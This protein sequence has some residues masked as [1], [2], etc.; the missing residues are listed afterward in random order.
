MMR[1]LSIKLLMLFSFTFMM[2]PSKAQLCNGSLGDP[3]VNITFGSGP[4]PGQPLKAATTS[5]SFLA[6]DC[7]NDGY[8]TIENRTTNCYNNTWYS[9]TA[10]HTGDPN[11]YFMLVNASY[12]PGAFYLDTVKGLCGGITYE[13]AA[14]ILNLVK[15]DASIRPNITFSIETTSGTVLQSY[16][17]G[18]ILAS[19]SPQWKQYGFY[20]TTPVNAP[21]I[22]LRMVNNAQGGIGNDVALDDITFR[23][24]GPKL[25]VQMNGGTTSKEVCQ[26]DKTSFAFSSSIT[27]SY[28]NPSYQW[29]VSKDKGV[30]WTDIAGATGTSY[31]RLP[32]DTGAYLYRLAVAE[33]DNISSLKCRVASNVLS[34]NVQPN[35]D[36]KIS[37]NNPGCT[38]DTLRL[39]AAS[40]GAT[41][42]WTGPNGFTSNLQNPVINK[43]TLANKGSYFVAL[44]DALGCRNRDSIDISFIVSPVANAGADV[45]ICEGASTSL[46]G[47]GGGTYAWKPVNAVAN[48]NSVTTIATPSDTTSYILTVSSG[49]C[50]GYDTVTVFVWKKP[51]ANA[52]PDQVIYE[53]NTVQLSGAAGGTAVS[54]SWSPANNMNNNNILNPVVS[55]TNDYTYSLNV[56]STLGCGTASDNVF[57]RV[58]KKITIPNVFSPNGDG[59]NDT[60]N[61]AQLNTYPEADIAV[62]NRYGQKVYE[63]T[64]YA[65]EWNGKY[66]GKPLPVGT[67]YYVID[68][69]NGLKPFSGW[70]MIVK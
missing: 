54:Y 35:P 9:L 8:Y 43:I 33:G 63:S 44:T 20:F 26:G 13:F 31:N 40:G 11:G 59:I 19:S 60:W 70:V 65:T 1:I 38:G 55:P 24:C 16:N 61:I 30:S 5:Y 34:I 28:N 62:F 47:S 21:Q 49:G 18:E 3:V 57:I 45:A 52:G 7:P 36:P 4:N 17:T 29:Q 68:L 23:P 25:T 10:D 6:A 50:K 41:Y 15:S 2:M 39:L 51:V 67:Y 53:G 48:P 69:K 12:Q 42:L 32:T 27:G 22:V 37:S 56:S 46:Q 58:Y 64:G 14:W 66:N